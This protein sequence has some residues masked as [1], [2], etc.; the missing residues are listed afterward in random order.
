MKTVSF[1]FI[2]FFD[3]KLPISLSVE[4][5]LHAWLDGQRKVS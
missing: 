1:L 5:E 4:K 3:L 2:F